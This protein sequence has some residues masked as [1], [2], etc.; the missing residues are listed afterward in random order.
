[1]AADQGQLAL[2][3]KAQSDFD[4]VALATQPQLSDTA[5]CMQSQAAF[6]SI[7]PPEESALLHY[8]MGYCALAAGAITHDNQDSLSAAAE[9][10]KAIE[11]W[12]NW[13]SW[14]GSINKAGKNQPPEPVPSGLRVLG[15]LARVQGWTDDAVR[16]RAHLEISAALANPTCTSSLMSAG[17]CR[18]VL[19]TGRQWL[20]WMALL[21]NDLDG[22]AKNFAGLNESGWPAW[23]AGRKQFAERKYTEAAAQYG[24]AI[25]IWKSVWRP[26]GPSFVRRL[27]P[28][29]DLGS[30]LADLGGA[31]LLAGDT[32]SAIA[33]LDAAILANPLSARDFYLRARAKEAAGQ[34]EQAMA[35]YNLASRAAFASAKDMVSGE[36][37]LYRGILFYLRKDFTRAE[38]EFASA[39]NF[40]IPDNLRSDAA[41]WRH[42]AAVA[43]GSCATARENLERSLAAVSPYFPKPE[44]RA[45]IASCETSAALGA[46]NSGK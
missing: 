31:Q 15:W 40:E 30:A 38:D 44:A 7:S 22:A 43:A 1:M 12:A 4:R 5:Q 25:E 20:G 32:K 11:N 17:F 36:A 24:R 10:E 39:L 14:P 16:G 13:A 35:D 6:L 3:L 26:P 21:Q 19:A 29:P 33:S 2:S 28:K 46:G 34:S 41:A 27:G 23:V 37:H 42:L 8:R 9:F 45:A 18:E